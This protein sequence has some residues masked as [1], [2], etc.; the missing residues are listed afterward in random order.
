MSIGTFNTNPEGTWHGDF[1]FTL[2]SGDTLA[3]TIEDAGGSERPD[4]GAGDEHPPVTTAESTG[5]AGGG[6]GEGPEPHC[7]FGPPTGAEPAVRSG[8]AMPG[9]TQHDRGSRRQRQDLPGAVQ[10]RRRHHAP[11]GLRPS[12]LQELRPARPHHQRGDDSVLD[13]LG[14]STQVLDIAMALEQ[15]AL[16]DDYF[17][18]RK[19]YP[20]VDFY[21]GIIYE[22]LDI[23]VNTFTVFFALGQD[24]GLDRAVARAE[25]GSHLPNRAP[26]ADLHR[27][28]PALLR[29]D[30]GAVTP[31]YH[32]DR[33][34][35][36]PARW[37]RLSAPSEPP[38]ERSCLKTRSP[39][40]EPS[41]TCAGDRGLMGG[42]RF[43][44]SKRGS[45]TRSDRV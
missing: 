31:P 39:V 34:R 19:F 32:V 9:S 10:R 42:R 4:G 36:H 37:P 14:K 29:P 5:G 25:P 45:T 21:S 15:T 18:S 28:Y 23:P 12:R 7:P 30:R 20:N 35:G 2:R 43:A 6:C 24:A 11:D 17:V 33:R 13:E 38:D 3:V 27:S 1:A 40:P 26:A 41:A 16:E 44:S 22:A 8:V